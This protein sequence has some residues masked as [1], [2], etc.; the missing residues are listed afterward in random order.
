[1]VTFLMFYMHSIGDS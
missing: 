1:M